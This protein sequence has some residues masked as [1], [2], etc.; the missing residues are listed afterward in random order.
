VDCNY[1]ITTNYN[2]KNLTSSQTKQSYGNEKMNCKKT[3]K[4]IPDY[5]LGELT[6]IET[7][8]IEQHLK[9]CP[10]CAGEIK[11]TKKVFDALSK[12]QPAP[13]PEYYFERFP[14]RV[15]E[16]LKHKPHQEIAQNRWWRQSP[17][18]A[19]GAVATIFV[20][21]M[22]F[23]VSQIFQ[24]DQ[25]HVPGTANIDA[26]DNINAGYD[27]DAG[28]NIYE[29]DII[30]PFDEVSDILDIDDEG[31]Y[32]S[33]SYLPLDADEKFEIYVDDE[34]YSLT[35]DEYKEL[36]QMLRNKFLS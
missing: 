19:S 15:M 32:S 30:D 11:T 22:L 34:L 1:T 33:L 31:S 12:S 36:L 10:K 35:E 23:Y 27:I 5:L 17:V 8:L 26:G 14:S 25:P 20:V 21:L 13:P 16:N 28:Y 29:Y 18:W 7:K 9:S 3:K 24:P 4:Q 6:E 2:K